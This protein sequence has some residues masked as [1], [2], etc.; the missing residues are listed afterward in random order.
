MQALCDWTGINA[1][2]TVKLAG[3]LTAPDPALIVTAPGATPVASP[4]LPPLL[5]TVAMLVFDE[6]HVAVVVRSSVEPSP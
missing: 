6:L 5:L 4:W 1:H 3:P 2:C